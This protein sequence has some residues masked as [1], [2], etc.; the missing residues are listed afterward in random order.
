MNIFYRLLIFSILAVLAI[1]LIS[2]ATELWLIA[3]NVDGKGIG[4]EFL[5]LEIND[6][7]DA[8]SIPNYVIGFF[9]ASFLTIV[10]GFFV[11]SR[12]DF[13]TKHKSLN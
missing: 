7:V 1:L 6:Q 2:K 11:L 4:I 10:G 13:K 9:I 12:S 8:K 3:T 5:G